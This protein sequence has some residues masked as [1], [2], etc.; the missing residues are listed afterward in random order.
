MASFLRV[1]Q[2]TALSG[3][4]VLPAFGCGRNKDEGT[5]FSEEG[6]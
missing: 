1:A 3:H 4:A 6:T 2:L 5:A